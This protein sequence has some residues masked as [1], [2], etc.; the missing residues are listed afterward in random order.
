MCVVPQSLDHL[1]CPGGI[2]GQSI[3]FKGYIWL[4][5]INNAALFVLLIVLQGSLLMLKHQTWA[6]GFGR[7]QN[8]L[9]AAGCTSDRFWFIC[10]ELTTVDCSAASSGHIW[11][12]KC[13]S[14]MDWNLD[15]F[16]LLPPAIAAGNQVH[17]DVLSPPLFFPH[18]VSGINRIFSPP[19]P[20]S[21]RHLLLLP[22]NPLL[23]TSAILSSPTLNAEPL[24][25]RIIQR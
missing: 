18:L 20:T 23:G 16:L 25:Y 3:P 7:E 5:D 17:V 10:S 15:R 21:N 4:G 24:K 9:S 2:R 8:Q 13:S 12:S 11:L 14:W 6:I 22:A 1:C 19:Y